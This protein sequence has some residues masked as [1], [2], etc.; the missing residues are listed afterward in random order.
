M[1]CTTHQQVQAWQPSANCS[2]TRRCTQHRAR[3]L[4]WVRLSSQ[5]NIKHP[6]VLLGVASVA[7]LGVGQHLAG[8]IKGMIA[9]AAC[10]FAIV[11]NLRRHRTVCRAAAF[12]ILKLA[13]RSRGTDRQ[14]GRQAGRQTDRCIDRWTDR[15]RQQ[16]HG[17]RRR[18]GRS[19][20]LLQAVL[21]AM[22]V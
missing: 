3:T 12:G 9:A 18:L 16:M 6:P 20:H 21:A 19:K 13:E 2:S 7:P 4:C 8:A 17:P 1:R 14:S 10:G 11:A 5:A 15:W 22:H